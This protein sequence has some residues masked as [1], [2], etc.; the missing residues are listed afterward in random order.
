MVI[1]QPTYYDEFRASIIDE[2][3]HQPAIII[4]VAGQQ[5]K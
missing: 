1:G 3:G 4:V 2:D 5:A